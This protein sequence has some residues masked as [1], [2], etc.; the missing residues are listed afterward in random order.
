MSDVHEVW[1]EAK[2]RVEMR[3]AGWRSLG[4]G[5]WVH[6]NG[7]KWQA[8]QGVKH[9]GGIVELWTLFAETRRT[10]PPY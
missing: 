8:Y 1:T 6:K 10:P 2:L 3:K 5:V 7:F 9:E 4:Q